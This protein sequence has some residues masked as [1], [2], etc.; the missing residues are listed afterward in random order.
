MVTAFRSIVRNI[1]KTNKQILLDFLK[2]IDDKLPHKITIIAV[3][4]T[5]LTLLNIKESTK[6]ID[7]DFPQKK[8]LNTIN[9]LFSDLDFEAMGNSWLTT[10]GLRLD[11]FTGGYIF[12]IQLLKDYIEE[13]KPIWELNN[14]TLKAL[15][16]YDIIITKIGRGDERD[17]DDIKQIY[18]TNKIDNDVLIKRYF[19][20][21]ESLPDAFSNSV[22]QRLFDL[23]D[24]KFSEWNFKKDKE[25]IEKIRKWQM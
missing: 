16:L 12:N 13:S 24:L 10:G 19:K 17:F 9:K 14:I 11:L 25:I 23:L 18:S 1:I 21:A 8:E 2:N 3:G 22:K 7:F 6:D 5:A 15:S 20:S 4:G